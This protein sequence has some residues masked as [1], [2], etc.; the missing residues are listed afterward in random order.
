[1]NGREHWQCVI[2]KSLIFLAE[3]TSSDECTLLKLQGR[4]NDDINHDL[5]YY[6]LLSPSQF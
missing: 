3:G 1:M 2:I 5:Y 4:K 6:I